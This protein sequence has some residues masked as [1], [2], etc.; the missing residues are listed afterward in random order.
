MIYID[1]YLAAALVILCSKYKHENLQEHSRF[2]SPRGPGE[3]FELALMASIL[4]GWKSFT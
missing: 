4:A 1:I 2:I 3:H